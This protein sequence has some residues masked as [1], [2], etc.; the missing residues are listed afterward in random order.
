[1]FNTRSFAKHRFF[2]AKQIITCTVLAGFLLLA[3]GCGSSGGG[4]CPAYGKKNH[5]GG[6]Q[7]RR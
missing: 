5:H 3:T 7:Y 6:S 4:G 2:N 1:M